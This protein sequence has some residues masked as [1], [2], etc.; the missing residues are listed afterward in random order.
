M[1][2]DANYDY[3]MKPCF[4]EPAINDATRRYDRWLDHSL[5][6]RFVCKIPFMIYDGIMSWWEHNLCATCPWCGRYYPIWT[7]KMLTCC[8]ETKKKY[9][10]YPGSQAVGGGPGGGSLDY[11]RSRDRYTN[12][13]TGGTYSHDAGSGY[14]SGFA[15]YDSA[16]DRCINYN[17]GDTYSRNR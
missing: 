10:R 7:K 5:L 2:K 14:G 3:L 6:F 16:R 9:G 13:D 17:T 15:E 1:K 12:S 4:Y 8:F 11:D